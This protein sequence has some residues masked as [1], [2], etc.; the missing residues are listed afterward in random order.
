MPINL[1]RFGYKQIN[2]AKVNDI[3]C[4]NCNKEDNQT[5]VGLNCNKCCEEQKDKSKYPNLNGPDYAFEKDFSDRIK[6]SKLFRKKNISPIKLI[7]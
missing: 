6:H 7:S 1:K 4:Y 5:C 2:D 3:I